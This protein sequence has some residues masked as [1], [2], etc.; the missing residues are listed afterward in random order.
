[1]KSISTW[2]IWIASLGYFFAFS[3]FV[4]FLPVY[5]LKVLKQPVDSTI[6]VPF[7]LLVDGVNLIFYNFR[8]L[9]CLQNMAELRFCK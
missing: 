7:I 9:S 3:V 6:A 4:N 2:V 8:K 5:V 1:M